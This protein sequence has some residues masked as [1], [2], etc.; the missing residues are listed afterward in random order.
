MSAQSEVYSA[1]RDSL[2]S[3]NTSSSP[4]THALSL[5]WVY[6]RT[7]S[8]PV[9]ALQDNDQQVVLYAAANVGVV[10]NLTFNSQ[11]VL[12]GHSQNLSCV[13]VSND[14]R[15]IV[16]ADPSPMII[17]WDS[18]SGIPVCTLF[19]CHPKHDVSEVLFSTDAR[20][21]VTVGTGEQQQQ[22]VCVWD[23]TCDTET[24]RCCS[25]LSPNLGL[26]RNFVFSSSGSELLSCSQTHVL[27]FTL[28]QKSLSYVSLRLK[29]GGSLDARSSS[30]SSSQCI[31]VARAAGGAPVQSAFH[32]EEPQVLTATAGGDVVVW[33]LGRGAGAARRTT[34]VTTIHLQEAPFTVMKVTDR[35]LV[36]G[37]SEGLVKFFG[38]NFVL[39]AFYSELLQE[40]VSSISF[41]CE[42]TAGVLLESP[43]RHRHQLIRNFIV[44][45][46]GSSVL[47]VNTESEET[48]SV[49]EKEP[50]P[51][52]ALCCHPSRP[53]LVTGSRDGALTLR[54]TRDRRTVTR[55]EFRRQGELTCVTYDPSGELL[56]VGFSSGSVDLLDSGSLR[57]D[58]EQDFHLSKDAITLLSFSED[59]RYL[60][61]A[62]RG[63]AVSVLRRG[64]GGRWVN[65]GR[66]R[67][68]FGPIQSLVFGL[69]LDSTL[70]RLLSLGLDRRLVEYDLQLH[71]DPAPVAP[72]APAP[73]GLSVLSSQRVE[74]RAVPLGMTWYP[75]LS[76]EQFLLI[77]SDQFKL[78]LINSTT[79]MCR[80][81]ILGPTYG[82]P[83]QK[84]L[85]LPKTKEDQS[86]NYH[87]V[88]ITQNMVGL[89]VL[90]ADGNPFKSQALVCHPSGVCSL[91]ASFDGAHVVTSGSNDFTTM[92]WSVCTEALEAAA[93]L[94][95]SGMEPFYNM[96]DGGRHGTFYK[97]MEELFFF[98]QLRLQ[99][100]DSEQR[101]KVSTTIPLNQVSTM[102][103]AIGFFP[104]EQEI[105]DLQNE[106]KFSR[107]AETG[108]Y[109]TEL[110]LEDLIK[111]Y[112][113]HRP[114]FGLVKEELEQAFNVLTGDQENIDRSSLLQI[115]QSQG[116][117]MTEDEVLQSFSSL[118][119]LSP[120][121]DSP[122]SSKNLLPPEVSV[123][124][125]AQI[126][127]FS[128]AQP[129]CKNMNPNTSSTSSTSSS[130]T[131]SSSSPLKI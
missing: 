7:P 35:C 62:D 45:G 129:T 74:Q 75:P 100:T 110:D 94:G 55:R 95:G 12:Q 47:H 57:S 25:E 32:W 41:S 31:S 14:R 80:K 1:T 89:Q 29:K 9:L 65:M 10:Y 34:D 53:L 60:A 84:L 46:S 27:H 63:F 117:A 93:A 21:L 127:G 82:S 105:E 59:A 37:D 38:Q 44:C 54:D 24:P 16:T 130:S 67:S 51:V 88:F 4:R 99:G 96:L 76:T 116:E 15:W 79:H 103:R 109:V 70:P 114:A 68:H 33:E 77:C 78:R 122:R 13:C 8:L 83:L 19:H 101:R 112:V 26:Q 85:V 18:Y 42:S 39:L 6:G 48:R 17:I 43:L 3:K 71:S 20:L 52:R 123:E 126:L 58:P 106:L 111:L 30:S 22:H 86:K 121:Q 98:L 50:E 108:Q 87:L 69:Q 125:L 115:L 107:Y 72:V 81:V 131:S 56:A 124:T 90:P 119:N 61:A 64:P 128:S 49:L 92:T 113:N 102:M 11:H 91:S 2:F 118:L 73:P 28:E 120:D 5:E 104:T 66:H 23:W 40:P 97:E 36:T